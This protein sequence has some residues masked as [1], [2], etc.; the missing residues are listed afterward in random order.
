M[1]R[2][3]L[4]Q[5]ENY[6]LK[7]QREGGGNNIFGDA[8]RTKLNE[9]LA[10]ES[11]EREAFVL[12]QRIRPY[13]FNALLY[14]VAGFLAPGKRTLTPAQESGTETLGALTSNHIFSLEAWWEAYL[15]INNYIW[16]FQI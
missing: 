6:V 14:R 8:L 15:E 4:E 3:A 16:R 1:V 9:L 13:T 11:G 2:D 5:P 10:D 7:P 12:M